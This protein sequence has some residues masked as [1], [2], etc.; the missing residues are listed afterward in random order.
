MIMAHA[1]Q[2][3]QQAGWESLGDNVQDPAEMQIIK[4]LVSMCT[5]YWDG[6]T[7]GFGS[8]TKVLARRM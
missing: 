4:S 7:V 8:I 2:G 6:G 1:C 5:G 3:M